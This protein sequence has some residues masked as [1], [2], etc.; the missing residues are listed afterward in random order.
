MGDYPVWQA[1]M[2]P[3]GYVERLLPHVVSFSIE[4]HEVETISK[5]H[6]PFPAE[7]RAS[8]A[9]HLSRSGR[10]DARRIAELIRQLES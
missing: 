4:I 5:L 9:D 6:Q 3:A 1:G 8:I 7:D 2:A 10:S